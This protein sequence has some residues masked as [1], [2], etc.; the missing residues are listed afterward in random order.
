MSVTAEIYQRAAER[1][2][3]ERDGLLMQTL[4]RSGVLVPGE[5]I[6][7]LRGRLFA[8]TFDDH[9][10][11]VTCWMVDDMLLLKTWPPTVRHEGPMIHFDQRRE[12]LT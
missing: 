5:S 12:V 9:G 10:T 11:P 2:T 6:E 8:I 3:Q 1:M 4:R 7:M